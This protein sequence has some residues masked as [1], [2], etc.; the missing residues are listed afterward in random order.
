M[1]TWPHPGCEDQALRVQPLDPVLELGA[2]ALPS[3]HLPH[4]ERPR[5]MILPRASV[6]LALRK[7]Y[8]DAVLCRGKVGRLLN[9][10]GKSMQDAQ[11]L[12]LGVAYKRDV[13]GVSVRIFF[14]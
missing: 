5:K 3:I 8:A 2:I 4:L 13:D 10:S 14:T 12:I 9:E 6:E 7:K 1:C 11:V